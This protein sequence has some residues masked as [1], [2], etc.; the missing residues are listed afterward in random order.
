[1]KNLLS[2]NTSYASDNEKQFLDMY[3]DILLLNDIDQS[4]FSIGNVEVNKTC[5]IMME[6]KSWIVFDRTENEL[7]NIKISDS[8]LRASKYFTGLITKD[9]EKERS[10]NKI[11]EDVYYD[12][13]EKEPKAITRKR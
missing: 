4:T 5:M 11:V 2:N 9:R 12:I 13:V 7:N 1:M 10:I 3:R 8:L 6:S